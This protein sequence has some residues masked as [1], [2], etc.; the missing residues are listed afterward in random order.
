MA[1]RRTAHVRVEEAGALLGYDPAEMTAKVNEHY[2]TTLLV[3]EDRAQGAH[4]DAGECPYGSD[5]PLDD[6]EGV[7][8]CADKW[9]ASMVFETTELPRQRMR[10]NVVADQACPECGLYG[11]PKVADE[12]GVWS[13]RCPAP[14]GECTVGYYTPGVGKVEDKVDPDSPEWKARARELAEQVQRD[15]AEHGLKVEV[16]NADGTVTDASI[17]PAGDE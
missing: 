9:I 15:I 1:R 5:H 4:H 2:Q 13:W 17:P 11:S 16:W 12:R 10:I 7:L 8:L 3:W 14:F 6:R